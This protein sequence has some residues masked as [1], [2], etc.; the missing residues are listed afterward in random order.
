M[1]YFHFRK[2]NCRKFSFS[3]Y[4]GDVG[5]RKT[6]HLLCSLTEV[7]EG[8]V[9]TSFVIWLVV[10][11]SVHQSST[12]VCNSFKT[13]LKIE[14]KGTFLVVRFCECEAIDGFK[15]SGSRLLS[16]PAYLCLVCSVFFH[17][18]HISLKSSIFLRCYNTLLCTGIYNYNRIMNRKE[19]NK[20]TW[21]TRCNIPLWLYLFINH[22][23]DGVFVM[24]C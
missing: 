12:C 17:S 10:C 21:V 16:F 4:I 5:Q 23:Q 24:I 18:L 15:E 9:V 19:S 3:W 2:W 8:Y 13:I 6:C 20:I 1:A 14:L 22:K 7:N 11:R